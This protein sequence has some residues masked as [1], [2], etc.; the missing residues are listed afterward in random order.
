M[1]GH[2]KSFSI[3]RVNISLPW[4]KIAF[5]ILVI[6][7]VVFAIQAK[8]QI[9]EDETAASYVT[10]PM[11]TQPKV[12]ERPARNLEGKKLVAL[13]FDDGPS[14]TTTP[15]LLDILL[16]K[17]TPVTFFDLGSRMQICP[18]IVMREINEGHEVESHTMYH[19]NL[20]NIS[21]EEVIKDVTEAKQVYK[22]LLGY[23][24]KFIRPPYGA[25][26][27][28]IEKNAGVPLITWSVDSLDWK[29]MEHDSILRYGQMF[30][31]DGGIILMHDIHQTTVDAVSD[32]IDVLRGNGYEFVTVSELIKMR[33]A[34]LE[35][36]GVYGAFHLED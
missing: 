27:E 35:N 13:T 7:F 15:Q 4:F 3:R 25:H 10:T 5:V 21:E 31:K 32:L 30:L 33:G 12:P 8:P 29:Y 6:L 20:T 1:S 19:Q 23:E 22:E 24:P 2:A 36:G 16:E 9:F 26:D 11:I 34:T 28:K 14:S 18:D 17:N